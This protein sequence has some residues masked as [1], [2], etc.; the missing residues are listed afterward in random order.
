GW[1]ARDLT[2]PK[3][4]RVPSTARVSA[5]QAVTQPGPPFLPP[6]AASLRPSP[7]KA[8]AWTGSGPASN[9]RIARP[10]ARSQRVTTGRPFGPPALA[11]G[12]ERDGR[13]RP[14]RSPQQGDRQPEGHVPDPD[15]RPVPSRR[16]RQPRAVGTE[17]EVPTGPMGMIRHGEHLLEL[18]ATL[19]QVD[20]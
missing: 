15:D 20:G 17:R 8:R 12:A 7:L 16:R 4:S 18:D 5:S 6:P 3:R 14:A 2:R 13:D 19:E 11:I 10:E 9:V 1:N